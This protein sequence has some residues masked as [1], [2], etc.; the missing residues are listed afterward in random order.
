VSFATISTREGLAPI[1]DDRA[2]PTVY[3]ITMQQ[4]PE[5]ANIAPPWPRIAA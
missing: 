1:A 2:T 3:L 4:P 5:Y